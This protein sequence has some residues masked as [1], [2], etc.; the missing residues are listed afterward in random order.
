MCL[1]QT[2]TIYSTKEPQNRIYINNEAATES[3]QPSLCTLSTNPP[4]V[5]F[6]EI[7]EEF[8]IN[9][10]RSYRQAIKAWSERTV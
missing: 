5:S 7:Y 9:R 10:V 3:V 1:A 2:L 6:T 4:E 8:A